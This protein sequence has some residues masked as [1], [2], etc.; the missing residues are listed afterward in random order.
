V[1]GDPRAASAVLGQ[2][3][4]DLIV[5]KS[6]GAIRAAQKDAVKNK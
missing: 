5:A 1:G 3:G 6:V 2:A 4:V